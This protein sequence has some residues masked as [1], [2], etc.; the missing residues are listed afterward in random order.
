MFNE[1]LQKGNNKQEM[2]WIEFVWVGQGIRNLTPL[3][4]FLQFLRNISA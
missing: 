2:F 1:T 4:S 3:Q